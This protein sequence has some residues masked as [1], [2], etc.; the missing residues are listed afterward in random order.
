MSVHLETMR[1]RPLQLIARLAGPAGIL[2]LNPLIRRSCTGDDQSIEELRRPILAPFGQEVEEIPDRREEVYAS[3][4]C[5]A[6][7]TGVE[8]CLV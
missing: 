1:V 5:A 7:R 2:R 4:V 3:V 6:V 8:G